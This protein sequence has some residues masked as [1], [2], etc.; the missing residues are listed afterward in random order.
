MFLPSLTLRVRNLVAEFAR[1][2]QR[3]VNPN[4]KRQRVKSN[5]FRLQSL[6][7]QFADFAG[8]IGERLPFDTDPVEHRHEEV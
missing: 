2:W 7:R 1:I 4:P 6:R 8:A 5:L 3:Q